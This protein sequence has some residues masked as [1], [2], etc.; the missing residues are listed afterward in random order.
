MT[1]ASVGP[2]FATGQQNYII[3]SGP[4]ATALGRGGSGG[5]GGARGNPPHAASV[6]TTGFSKVKSNRDVL[7]VGLRTPVRL[8]ALSTLSVA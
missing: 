1:P 2:S 5:R 4:H 6:L 8:V 3:C 7:D